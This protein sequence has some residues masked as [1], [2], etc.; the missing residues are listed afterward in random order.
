M[1]ATGRDR[2]VVGVWDATASGAAVRWAAQEAELRG[3][4]LHLLHAVPEAATGDVTYA[5][6]A[7]AHLQQLERAGRAALEELAA[8]VAATRPQL[9]VTTA[10]ERAP[11]RRALVDAAT[12]GAGAVLL[13]VGARRRRAAAALRL[14]S[15]ALHLAAHAPCPLAVVRAVPAG[16]ARGVV[17]GHDGSPASAAAVR[18]AAQRALAAEEALHLVRAHDTPARRLDGWSPQLYE[19]VRAADGAAHRREVEEAAARLREEHPGLE[20]HVHL[21]PDTDPADALTGVAA[22]AALLVV[23]ARGHGAFVSALLGSASHDVLHRASG[24]VVVVPDPDRVHH[25]RAA[26]RAAH[27]GPSRDVNA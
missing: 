22:R 27:A 8:Q 20:V 4:D 17:V 13:V 19:E 6:Y 25:Q 15:T 18:F 5:W 7:A 12:H 26:R 11:V 2:V 24:P 16:D 21:A 10:L 14:G 9:P 23:G 1:T 3:A